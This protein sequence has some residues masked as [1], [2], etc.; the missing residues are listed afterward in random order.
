MRIEVPFSA[1]KHGRHIEKQLEVISRAFI[2][3]ELDRK[4]GE[5]ARIPGGIMF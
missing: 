5:P 4:D 3:A 1:R 2:K